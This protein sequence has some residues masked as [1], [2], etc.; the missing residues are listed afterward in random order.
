MIVG[1]ATE[2]PAEFA[3]RFGDRQIVDARVT[4]AHEAVLVELPIFVAI[5]S[6]PVVRIIVP[7][8]SEAH[9][10]ARSVEGPQLFDQAVVELARPFALKESD[11]LIAALKNLRAVPPAAVEG[12]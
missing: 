9:R 2:R 8:V 11:D 5:R 6:K 10:D 7:F 3:R 12:V 4:P 1:T